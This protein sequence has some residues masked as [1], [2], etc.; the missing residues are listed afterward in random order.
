MHLEVQDVGKSYYWRLNVIKKCNGKG[1]FS[2]YNFKKE[3][4][5]PCIPY[6][7]NFERNI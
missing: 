6:V 5:K 4:V 2:G 1:K 7:H 3:N